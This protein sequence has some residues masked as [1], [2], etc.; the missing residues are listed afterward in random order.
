MRLLGTEKAVTFRL[1]EDCPVLVDGRAAGL[2][3]LKPGMGLK[4][5]PQE[6]GSDTA[7]KVEA[8][9]G[10]GEGTVAKPT[11]GDARA[12]VEK[13]VQAH[14]GAD[15]LKK[16]QAWTMKSKGKFY[17]RGEALEYTA[18]TKFQVPN[19]SRIELEWPGS[20][21]TQVLNGE[22]GWMSVNG[23]TQEM[24]K[25]LLTEARETAHA[26]NLTL[27]VPLL[28][29]DC[30][31]SSLGEAKVSDRAAVGVRVSRK[32]FRDVSLYFDKE[33]GLLVKLERRAKDPMMGGAEYTSEVAYGDYK[34]VDGVQVAF[35]R[36][37][38][39]DGKRIDE[40]EIISAEP[41]E[42]LDDTA[43]E[44]DAVTKALVENLKDKDPT[45]RAT[46]AQSLHKRGAKAAVPALID[47]V[48]DDLMNN[49]PFGIRGG[50][51]VDKSA[52]LDALKALAPD[53]V[54]E[55]LLRARKSSNGDVREWATR[56]LGNLKR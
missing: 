6:E 40:V 23:E 43:G 14:G 10:K 17:G 54:E 2:G 35:K 48:A 1:A 50:H 20:K 8:E 13:A 41:A 3:D 27:I 11:P 34:K 38:K 30:K 37:V 49:D 5:T 39:R 19:K 53:R 33:N 51:G 28:S 52:A 44:L 25:D 9:A 16:F 56:E 26:V 32:G 29:E 4:V 18:E 12:I 7:V 24:N 47:R 45:V 46:A 55:A 31:L 21:F 22:R 36:T 15:V 42:K